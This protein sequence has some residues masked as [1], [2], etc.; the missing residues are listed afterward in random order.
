MPYDRPSYRAL[1]V[2]SSEKMNTALRS[3]LSDL[4]CELI[5]NTDNIAHARRLCLE[6]AFDLVIVNAPLPDDPGIRFAIDVSAGKSS[7]CLLMIRSEVFQDIEEKVTSYG[8]MT[9]SKPTSPA[10][11]SQ[12]LQWMSAVRERLR[13]TELQAQT[14]ENKMQ[15]IRIVNRAKLLL[16]EKKGLSEPEAHR[17]I[18]KQAMD[19]C[20]SRRAVAEELIRSL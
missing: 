17:F 5:R 1:I 9:L 13:R 20:I 14:L 8:V 2:S 18:E 19:R 11:L 3:L 15:D 6:N 4:D 10:I 16:I 12:S 7:V